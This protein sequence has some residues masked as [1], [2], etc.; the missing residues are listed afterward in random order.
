MC[1]APASAKEANGK[2]ATMN[3]AS[4]I[5][6]ALV[7][8]AG[9]Y[10]LVLL[11]A[12]IFQHRLLYFPDTA[13]VTPAAAGL[14]DVSERVLATPDG[15]KVIA[16]TGPAAPGRPTLVFFHGNGGSVAWRAALLAKYRARGFGVAILSYRGYGG[17]TGMP[18]E[19]ANVADARLL[20][21]SLMGTGVAPGDIVL[22]GE[23]LGSGV[24]VQAAAGRAFGGV[25]LDS[26]YTSVADRAAE[27]Y[28]FLP[29][30]L[31][32]RDTY[33][34][35]RHIK[36]LRAPLLIV[37][38]EADDMIPVAMGRALFAAAGEPKRLVTLPGAGHNNHDLFGSFEAVVDW[39]EQRRAGA[40]PPTK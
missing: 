35:M 3:L 4:V 26:P 23:S 34:S 10:V 16:W 5:K 21:D 37:H 19:A 11:A 13:R 15:E 22:Y 39:I 29:V 40:V 27:L 38:G 2:V 20:L 1:Y 36:A 18:S 28:R 9:L 33:D 6:A 7:V 25:V 30:R 31:L 17:S 8:I 32:I 12:Y 24:A 14:A